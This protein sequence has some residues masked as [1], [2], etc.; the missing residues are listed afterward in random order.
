MLHYA[1]IKNFKALEKILGIFVLW[2]I[3]VLIFHE[4]FVYSAV[5]EQY[6]QYY[7]IYLESLRFTIN[8]ILGP[9]KITL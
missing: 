5:Y 4:D 8:F 9:F 2:Y 7:I 6:I 3:L 1:F